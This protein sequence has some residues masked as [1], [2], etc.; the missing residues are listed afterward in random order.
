[1]NHLETEKRGILNILN[2]ILNIPNSFGIL[3]NIK[4]EK[5][6][7]E[8]LEN[9]FSSIWK[10]D[11]KDSLDVYPPL[12]DLTFKQLI[13]EIIVNINNNFNMFL[14]LI[15]WNKKFY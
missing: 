8:K 2:G 1:M 9:E 7:K 4:K 3:N 15:L 10:K 5:A 14:I 11:D 12:L 6:L 13:M